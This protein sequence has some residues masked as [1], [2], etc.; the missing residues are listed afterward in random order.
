M[1]NVLAILLALAPFCHAN[2]CN[3][4]L[5]GTWKSD[6]DM[7]MAFL[8]ENSKVRP[9]A[10]AFL[11]AL[12]GHFT[13]TFSDGELHEVLPDIDAP[14]SGEITR[15]TGS[16]D[17][18]AYDVLFCN[19]TVVVWSAK[20]S[21]GGGVDATTFNF[22]GPD[23]VW[24][25]TGT[26]VPGVPDLHA[27]EYFRRIRDETAPRSSTPSG[28]CDVSR[29]DFSQLSPQRTCQLRALAKRCAVSDRCQIECEA[30]GGVQQV[31]GGC[32]HI[33][34]DG[35][36][37]QTDEDIARNGGAYATPESTACYNRPR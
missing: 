20:R 32:Q 9:E 1:K 4:D 17:R 15:F 3:N 16:E 26:T 34:E 12:L 10:E 33:C 36:A 29:I 13:L 23:T 5:A 30:R 2:A 25:Y 6:K 21:F 35:G 14:V 7:S 24:V 37:G 19:D 11:D 27:R 31:G 28:A 22:V 8:R 18:K